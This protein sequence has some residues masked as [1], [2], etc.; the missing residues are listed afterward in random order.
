MGEAD[1]GLTRRAFL[2]GGA[3]AVAAHL[4]PA[5]LARPVLAATLGDVRPRADWA[6]GLAPRGPL[7]V[8][9][10]GDVRFLL[11]HH[12]A[13]ANTYGPGD[14]PGILRSFYHHHTGTKGWPDLAYNFLVD[15]YGTVWEG[16]A[17]SLEDPVK[18]DATGGSQGFAL[19][20]CLVGDHTSEPPTSEAV[21]ALAR[22][23]AGLAARYGI[24]PS[25][26]ARASF[27]S[28]GSSRHPRGARVE[29]ATIAG[30]RDMSTTSCPGDAAYELVTSGLPARVVELQRSLVPAGSAATRRSQPVSPDRVTASSPARYRRL[31]AAL[32][33][34]G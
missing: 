27:V 21:E 23:L 7:D 18:G 26:G 8:E 9:A 14:M 17:G 25:P 2:L 22:L 24:D 10:P 13:S 30:H 32:R 29:T 15:R 16:R 31:R 3:G 33:P 34:S 1:P 11:V 12:S 6:D 28:R 4:L 19:L 20:A 5:L